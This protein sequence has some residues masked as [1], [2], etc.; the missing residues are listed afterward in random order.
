MRKVGVIFRRE[1]ASYFRS[2]IAYVVIAAFIALTGYFFSIALFATRLAEMGFTLANLSVVILFIAPILTLKSLV[3][4]RRSGT[5]ELLL[6]A[7]IS[8]P[9]IVVGKFLA[10]V[11]IYVV[12][13]L[14]SAIFPIILAILGDP[15][16]GPIFTGYL[17]ILLLGSALIAAGIFASSLTQDTMIAGMVGFVMMF[18]LWSFSWLSTALPGNWGAIAAKLALIDR[19][20]VFLRGV[21]DTAD[22]LFYLS[23]IFVFLFLA[24]RVVDKRRW[25]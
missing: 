13:L 7:P 1:L 22:V 5:D 10:A 23:Y 11:A 14:V 4:E 24:I 19:F 3:D 2:P 6:T 21:V 18:A 8:V 25:S 9:A 17:G 16:P 20:D 15:D 12:M